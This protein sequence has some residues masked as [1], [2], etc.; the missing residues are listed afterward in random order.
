MYNAWKYQYNRKVVGLYCIICTMYSFAFVAHSTL[1]PLLMSCTLTSV[2]T[3]GVYTFYQ[4]SHITKMGFLQTQI[5]RAAIAIIAE[6][7]II[8]T[9]IK[10]PY[11]L[12]EY[13]GVP[14][15]TYVQTPAVSFATFLVYLELNKMKKLKGTKNKNKNE[16]GNDMMQRKMTVFKLLLYSGTL[17]C[18]AM[19]VSFVEISMN[20]NDVMIFDNFPYLHVTIHILEQIGIY[21]YGMGVAALQHLVIFDESK[22][23]L[24]HATPLNIPYIY[25]NNAKK[26]Q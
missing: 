9:V 3:N 17:L 1:S 14:T 6:S 16:N 19:A 18:M 24:Y 13:G 10:L 21:N 22:S 8:F 26:T 25:R 7:V 12:G 23:K 20:R 11:Q 4:Y 5:M 2:M 15:L